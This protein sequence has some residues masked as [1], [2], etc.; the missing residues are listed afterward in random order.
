MK[1]NGALRSIAGLILAATLSSACA[2]QASTGPKDNPPKDNPRV[3]GLVLRIDTRGGLLPPAQA[4]TQIPQFSLYSDGQILTQ[5]AQIE[6][7][8]GPALSPVF[9]THVSDDGFGRI[10][11]NAR[12]AGLEGPDRHY[13]FPGVADAATTTFT[14]VENGRRH[15]ISAYALGIESTSQSIPGSERQAR[16]KLLELEMRLGNLRGW[17]PEGSLSRDVPFAYQ[18]LTVLVTS[19][20][21][22]EQ[23]PEPEITWPLDRSI[24]KLATPVNAGSD[25]SCFT[26]TDQNL[27]KLR[28]LVTRANQLTPWKNE[29]KTYWLRFRP[30]LPDESGCPEA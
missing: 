9:S 24:A 3:D 19:R 13:D 15:V 11:K 6:I 8:P 4:M 28:P 5:G 18:G 2:S 29:T 23:M 12:Q 26:V 16:A 1:G 7:Y 27:K 20:P 25:V 21:E 17:L 10:I 30:L 14:F 22:G